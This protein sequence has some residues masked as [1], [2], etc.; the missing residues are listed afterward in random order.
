MAVNAG[1]L[2]AVVSFYQIDSETVFKR[3]RSRIPINDVNTVLVLQKILIS[4]LGLKEL[5]SK[6]GLRDFDVKLYY[7]AP[8]TGGK[9]KLQLCQLVN[10]P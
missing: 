2:K 5:S 6:Y 7:M 3:H 4:F 1:I 9:S 8:K 10:L